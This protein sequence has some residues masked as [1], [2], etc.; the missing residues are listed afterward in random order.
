MYFKSLRLQDLSLFV[1]INKIVLGDLA[2]KKDRL[3]YLLDHVSYVTWYRLLFFNRKF[4]CGKKLAVHNIYVS[5]LLL[6][7]N[8]NCVIEAVAWRCSVKKVFL[9]ISQNSQESNCAGVS[10]LIMLQASGMQRY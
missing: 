2:T 8:R 10:F 6:W 5:R 1:F 7:N 9:E 4:H 3:L